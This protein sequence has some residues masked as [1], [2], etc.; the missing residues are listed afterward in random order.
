MRRTVIVVAVLAIAVLLFSTP[1]LVAAKGGNGNGHG[2][3]GQGGWGSGEGHG[4]GNGSTWFNLYGV[5]DALDDDAGAIVVTAKSPLSLVKHNPITVETTVD[6]RFR[7]CELGERISFD[8]L[9]VGAPV[10]IKGLVKDG[11]F[12]ANLVILKPAYVPISLQ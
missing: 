7:D 11:V 9:E 3:G 6:T 2:G 5:I 10:R 12:V 4:G 1:G 8:E